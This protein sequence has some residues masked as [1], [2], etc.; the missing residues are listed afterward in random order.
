MTLLITLNQHKN[1]I[2]VIFASLTSGTMGKL[3][4]RIPG[5]CL[6][7]LSFPGS[8]LRTHVDHSASLAMS[9]RIL[10]AL[11]DKL[12]IKRH[13]PSILYIGVQ[14]FIFADLIPT[15]VQ[16]SNSYRG[17][18]YQIYSYRGSGYQYMSSHSYKG[19]MLSTGYQY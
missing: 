15:E 8:A 6:L 12:D 9:T 10:K 14:L 5:S 16:L 19:S 11:P 4:N 2:Y 18:G 3:I 7:I 13:S 17:M 1:P